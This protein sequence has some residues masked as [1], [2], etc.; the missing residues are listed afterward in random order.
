MQAL[1]FGVYAGVFCCFLLLVLRGIY[2]YW[3]FVASGLKQMEASSVLNSLELFSWSTFLARLNRGCALDWLGCS[4]LF[5]RNLT[6]LGADLQGLFDHRGFG[7][8]FIQWQLGAQ[9]HCVGARRLSAQQ[10]DS[11]FPVYPATNQRGSAQSLSNRKV[12]FLQGFVQQTMESSEG[13]C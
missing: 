1:L 7:L 12:V 9:D 13:I 6:R 3:I 4:P 11:S 10:P 5:G 8:V 2:H